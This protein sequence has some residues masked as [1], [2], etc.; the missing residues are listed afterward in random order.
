ML[1]CGRYDD[2][3][4]NGS[5]PLFKASL[6]GHSSVVELLVKAGVDLDAV[7]ETVC[8]NSALCYACLSMDGQ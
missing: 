7:E 5:T 2:W 4:K 6:G 8:S 3:S 1:L